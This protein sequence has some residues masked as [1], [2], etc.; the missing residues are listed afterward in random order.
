MDIA[1]STIFFGILLYVIPAIALLSAGGLC[2]FKPGMARAKI[3]ISR[4]ADGFL[5]A[6]T[7]IIPL[8]NII[9][10]LLYLH[11]KTFK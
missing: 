2:I 5:L 4:T 8:I 9:I 11:Y 3:G 6:V 10:I 7:S 1:F